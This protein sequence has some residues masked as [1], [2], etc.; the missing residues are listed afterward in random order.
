MTQAD[1]VE[2]ERR[3]TWWQRVLVWAFSILLTLLIYWLLGFILNDIGRLQGPIW[4]DFEAA[5]LDPELRAAEG[6]LDDEIAEVD[7]QLA[8]LQRRQQLLRDSTASSQ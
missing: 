6:R 3:G 2:R 5:Q 7:R 8:N 4:T 1:L